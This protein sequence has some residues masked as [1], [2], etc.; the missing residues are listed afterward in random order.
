MSAY[1]YYCDYSLPN[2]KFN[3]IQP[4]KEYKFYRSKLLYYCE[5]AID[6]TWLTPS[7]EYATEGTEIDYCEQP[8]DSS[9]LTP[10]KEYAA[11]GIE[12]NYCEQPID[13]T[14]EVT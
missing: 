11:E 1:G 6:S 9:W 4:T 14:W 12:I 2:A 10:N 7:K 8:I 5:Q 3:T 13:S